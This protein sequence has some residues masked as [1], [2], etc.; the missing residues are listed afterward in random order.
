MHPATTGG[1]G[2]QLLDPNEQRFFSQFLDELVP[3]RNPF[4]PIPGSNTP[5]PG[6]F[7]STPTS[8]WLPALPTPSLLL[9][10][11]APVP[12][13]LHSHTMMVPQFPSQVP[14]PPSQQFQ[15]PHHATRSAA[16]G[17]G[18]QS[19]SPAAATAAPSWASPLSSDTHIA[20]SSSAPQ[21]VDAVRPLPPITIKRENS[22]PPKKGRADSSPGEESS[23]VKG[24]YGTMV[25]GFAGQEMQQQAKVVKGAISTEALKLGMRAAVKSKPPPDIQIPVSPRTRN[26]HSL[27]LPFFL[28]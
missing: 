23:D 6:P 19:S 24:E 21:F 16:H 4:E 12:P 1:G 25:F 22:T 26:S 18:M 2:E 9:P 13:L 15:T 5:T 10:G 7:P 8:A 17:K 3:S 14:Q 27:L 28:P 20:R 11:S